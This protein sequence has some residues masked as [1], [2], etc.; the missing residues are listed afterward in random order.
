MVYGI[1]A[2]IVLK[3]MPEPDHDEYAL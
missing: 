3:V 2:T 1:P